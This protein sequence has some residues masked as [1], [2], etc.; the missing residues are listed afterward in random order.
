MKIFITITAAAGASAV[1][2]GLSFWAFNTGREGIGALFF[3]GALAVAAIAG[4][5]S[6]TR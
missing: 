5:F 6:A 1:P 3:V 2:F 4:F